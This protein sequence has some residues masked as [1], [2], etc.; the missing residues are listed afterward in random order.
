VPNWSKEL[1]RTTWG[2]LRRE[3]CLRLTK[4]PRGTLTRLKN[5]AQ[6][7]NSPFWQRAKK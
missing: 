2:I 6:K 7:P 1:G 4:R 5:Q 3:N